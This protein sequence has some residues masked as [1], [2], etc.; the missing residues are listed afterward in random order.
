MT[1]ELLTKIRELFENSDI[2]GKVTITVELDGERFI[3]YGRT[4]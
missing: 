4:E 2:E 1:D 3:I